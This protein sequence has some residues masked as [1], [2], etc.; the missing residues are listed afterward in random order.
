MFGDVGF[1]YVYFA[2]GMHFCFNV[3]AKDTKKEAGAVLIRA[4]KPEKGINLIQ[5]T[6]AM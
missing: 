5:K 6:E 3:V 4:I 2:Y 1:A